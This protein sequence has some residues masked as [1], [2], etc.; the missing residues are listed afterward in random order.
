MHSRKLVQVQGALFAYRSEP[1]WLRPVVTHRKCPV[2]NR[3]QVIMP[4]VLKQ[5]SG[6]F[7]YFICIPIF[8]HFIHSDCYKL[9]VSVKAS[10][11]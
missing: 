1:K 7:A 6:F 9:F 3:L 11:W 8:I 10:Q 4:M 5:W 2:H